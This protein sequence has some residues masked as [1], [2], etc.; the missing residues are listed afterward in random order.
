VP[1]RNKQKALTNLRDL[2]EAILGQ[3][4]LM[5]AGS[6]DEFAEWFLAGNERLDILINC[7]GVMANLCFGVE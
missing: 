6:I 3:M 4:D 7:A 2:P 5:D 1:A